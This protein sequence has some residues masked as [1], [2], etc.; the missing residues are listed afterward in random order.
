MVWKTKPTSTGN[1]LECIRSTA[2]CRRLE[3]I[4]TKIIIRPGEGL[5][6]TNLLNDQTEIQES[7]RRFLELY[8]FDTFEESTR[9]TI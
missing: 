5:P 9:F 8:G 1:D 4:R 3:T 2:K 6:K 7:M